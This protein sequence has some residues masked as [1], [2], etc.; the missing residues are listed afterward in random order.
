MQF[1]ALYPLFSARIMIATEE[2]SSSSPAQL[3]PVYRV[4]RKVLVGKYLRLRV[5]RLSRSSQLDGSACDFI[6][7]HQPFIGGLVALIS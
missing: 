7:K 1:L 6:C 4:C 2:E 5:K 3:M